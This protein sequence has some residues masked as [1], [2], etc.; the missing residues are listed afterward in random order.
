MK[1]R[2]K[3]K[4]FISII[5]ALIILTQLAAC[6]KVLQKPNG[7]Q[8][9]TQSE[10]QSDKA[11]SELTELENNIEMIIKTLGGPAAQETK[12]GKQDTSSKQEKKD[13]EKDQDEGKN[14]EKS[15]DKQG[16]K[17]QDKQG[18]KS[19]QGDKNQQRGQSRQKG[20]DQEQ[21]QTPGTIQQPRQP[22]DPMGKIVPLV[23]NLHYRWNNLLPIA[24]KQGAKKDLVDNF[25]NALNSL[26]ETSIGKNK[27]N[28]LMAANNLYSYIPDLYSLFKTKTSPEIKRMRYYSRNAILNSLTGNWTQADSDIE[29]LKSTWSL[30]KK[31]LS[32]EQQDMVN[33]LDFSIY[34]FEKVVKERN[35]T[36]TD[37]KGRVSFSNIE[38]LEKTAGGE[39]SK[40]SQSKSQSSGEQS[41]NQ[42][43][44][45]GESSSAYEYIRHLLETRHKE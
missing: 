12:R 21:D 40:G 20:Q 5:F 19:Q 30:Y 33:K 11:P 29:N 25:G 31:V 37:I 4:K 28:T 34:E 44:G 9:S 38:A 6:G 18:D 1:V 2:M 43:S 7:Q 35:Q 16:D 39:S 42:R 23:N 8:Q 26:T 24:V 17:D 22:Q 36:L 45:G 27:T 3:F 10:Q 32:N 13:A 14:K 15:Q 41:D